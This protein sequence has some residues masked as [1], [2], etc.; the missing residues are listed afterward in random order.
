MSET[1]SIPAEIEIQEYIRDHRFMGRAVYPAV[2]AMELISRAVMER[3]NDIDVSRIYDACFH[4]FLELETGDKKIPITIEI[5][6]NG[7]G[8]VTAS[9]VSMVTTKSGIT[10]KRAHVTQSYRRDHEPFSCIPLDRASALEGICMTVP[11]D[12]VYGECVPFGPAYRNIVEAAR[13]SRYGASCSVSGGLDTGIER[14]LGS[15]FPLDAAFHAASV[16]GQRYLGF[17]PFPVGAAR[18]ITVQP[19]LPGEVYYARI[20]PDETGPDP[21]FD[22]WIHDREGILHETALGVKM[23]DTSRGALRP[24]DWIRKG[25]D[26]L[27][28]IGNA[29]PEYV[30]MEIDSLA[31]FAEKC[32]GGLERERL[33]GCGKK[34]GR[35]FLAGRI[36]VKLLARK[37]SGDETADPGE[38]ITV[39]EDRE[40]PVFPTD[41]NR[42]S[43]SH[44]DRFAFTAASKNRVGVDV[45][46]IS[47]R[48]LKSRR[49]FMKDA[50]RDL[51]ANS[52]L[53]EV[54]ASLRVWS[55]KECVVKA[56]G[57]KLPEAWKESEVI[58]IG[59][60][61][62]SVLING[63][64]YT[65]YHDIVDGHLFT[66]LE[67]S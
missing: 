11:K 49:L 31:G 22:I 63:K 26:E 53:G 60:E 66:C 32:L 65:A 12:R 59:P 25:R 34:R 67:I 8:V 48:V 10:R 9:L 7:Q 13:L 30:I 58:V 14:V 42:C 15:P 45:E 4:R 33:Q 37:L 44:D 61:K 20:I 57:V 27:E 23:V 21:V 17:I 19:A 51:T 40:D 50:E 38:M 41:N 36:A 3:C 47:D 35:S 1:L 16:W 5:D 29:C 64:E 28:T 46:R 54:E 43:L 24:P 18:R 39:Q 2:E 6:D 52:P 56:A 62:S 55:V